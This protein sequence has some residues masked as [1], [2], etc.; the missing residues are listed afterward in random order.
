LEVK[1]ALGLKDSLFVLDRER[2]RRGRI[3]AFVFI[4]HGWGHGVGLCQT[5]AYGL[6]REGEDF[7]SILK[8]YYY[9]VD[10]VRENIREN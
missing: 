1:S 8:T 9:N 5:G 7:E 6:A 4:G 10:V 2:D 3:E